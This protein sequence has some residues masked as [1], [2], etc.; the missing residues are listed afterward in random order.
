MY[1]NNKN[2]WVTDLARPARARGVGAR[3]PHNAIVYIVHAHMHI[4]YTTRRG[5]VRVRVEGYI[6]GKGREG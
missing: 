2:G 6:I 5:R 4:Q 3:G 1:T